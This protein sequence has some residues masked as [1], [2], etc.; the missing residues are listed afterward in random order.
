MRIL[1]NLTDL[2]ALGFVV[3][4]FQTRFWETSLFPAIKGRLVRNFEMAQ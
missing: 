4:D 3:S 2:Y 1:P